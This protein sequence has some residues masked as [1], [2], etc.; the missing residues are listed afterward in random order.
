MRMWRWCMRKF[1]Q[2]QHWWG[3]AC[4]SSVHGNTGGV[5]C[6]VW[7]ACKG[8]QSRVSVDGIRRRRPE[9]A[10]SQR[11]TR[12]RPSPNVEIGA[13]FSTVLFLASLQM[14]LSIPSAS[15]SETTAASTALPVD[16]GLRC[17]STA[18]WALL[19]SASPVTSPAGTCAKANH[20]DAIVKSAPHSANPSGK[21]KRKNAPRVEAFPRAA[22]R[23]QQR[24][25]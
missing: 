6:A 10:A 2:Q 4:V 8:R 13:F 25:R 18:S 22:A 7:C 23:S 11:N 16:P 17:L 20:D 15:R 14:T 21:E 9:G 12:E 1:G 5:G 24:A 3:G 19:D